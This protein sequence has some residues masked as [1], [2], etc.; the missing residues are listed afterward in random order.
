MHVFSFCG[1]I[2]F[3]KIYSDKVEER[4]D[5]G[6]SRMINLTLRDCPYHAAFGLPLTNDTQP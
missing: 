3:G 6:H 1:N 5:L 4:S 2:F